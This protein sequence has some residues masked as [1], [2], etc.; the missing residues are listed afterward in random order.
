MR[1]PRA[2]DR[3]FEV[4]TGFRWRHK[5]PF[6]PTQ[7]ADAGERGPLVRILHFHV[8]I[9]LNVLILIAAE[10]WWGNRVGTRKGVD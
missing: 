8:R 9:R 10:T 2:R 4:M 1:Y 7:R 6:A 3:R 5:L